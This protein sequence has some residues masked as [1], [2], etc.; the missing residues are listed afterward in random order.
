MSDIDLI[1][2]QPAEDMIPESPSKIK[3]LKTSLMRSE[4]K[5]ER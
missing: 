2:E 4:T 1:K 3:K 5:N